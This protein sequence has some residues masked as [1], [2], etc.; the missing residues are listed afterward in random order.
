MF[1]DLWKSSQMVKILNIWVF[2]LLL[3]AVFPSII[4]V[5]IPIK[6]RIQES[7]F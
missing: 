1:M 5:Q 3:H 7:V 2:I 4:V 6:G